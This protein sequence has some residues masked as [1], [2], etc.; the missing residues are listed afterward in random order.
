MRV[1]GGGGGRRRRPRSL[2]PGSRWRAV[3]G[4][5]RG[6]AQ[7]RE[8]ECRSHG[9]THQLAER[10]LVRA[11]C[12]QRGEHVFVKGREGG[13]RN[14]APRSPLRASIWLSQA[15]TPRRSCN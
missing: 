5:E 3:D 12:R 13:G 10:A 4:V 9:T 14:E 1:S 15:K 8:L 6:L 2:R 7:R 11:T